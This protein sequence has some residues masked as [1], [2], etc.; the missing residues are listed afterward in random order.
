MRDQ[1]VKGL[2]AFNADREWVEPWKKLGNWRRAEVGG[3]K[4]NRM[5]YHRKGKERKGG[6]SETWGGK[7]GGRGA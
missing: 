3:G 2:F 5:L 7:K 4:T 1:N 6:N